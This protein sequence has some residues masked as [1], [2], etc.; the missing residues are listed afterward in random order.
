MDKLELVNDGLNIIDF[1]QKNQKEIQKTYGRSSI[2]QPS[3]KDRTKAWEDFLQCTSGESEQ[4]E[5]GM[6]KDDGG[7]E[8]RSLED[9]SSTSPTDG[10]IGK[11]VSN[12]RDWAEGS[13]DIQLDPVVTD[14]V[15]HD[16][17]GECTGYGFTSSPERGWSDHSS[18]ANNGDVCLVSDAKVLSY[19]P[20]IAVS[21]EDRE[22]DLVHLEDKLSATGLN[23]TAIPFTPK[24]LSVPAKDSPVIAEH[25]YGLGVR[26][27][28]VDPETNRN[29]NLDSIKL[30]TSDDEE[31]DQLEFEDE[32]AGSSS[33]VIVG[34]SP[35]EEEPSSAGRK[36]IESVG[37]ILEGQS[38]RDS[39]QIKGNK[40]ADAPGAGLK[41]SAVKEK[42]PQKRLPMLAEE[43]ECS[44]SEDPIIQ[45]LLKENSFINSQQGKDAQPLYY[46]SIEGSRSPDKTEITS[47]AVQNADKQRPGTPM[48]KSRG[49]PIKKGTDEK[50]PSAGTENVLGSKS[51]ATRHVRGSPPYQEGKSVNAENVRLNVPTVVKGT[52]KSEANPADDNDSLDDK[53]IMPSDDFSNTFFPHDTDRLNYHADHLGDY[54]LE[55]LCEESVLMGVINS[56]KL[57]NLDM[58]LNHIEEQVKEIPK[59]INK[60]E[61]ID[62]VLAKTNTALSTI[63]G[64]LVSM[65]IMIPGKGKGE[66]KGKSN[67]ELK[68]VIG[69][70]VLEQQSLFS[71]DNVKNFRD[72]SLTN[73]PYGTAVQ[74][75]GDLI[76]PE[77]NFEETNASQFVPMADDSSRDVVKTLIR[78]HIKDRELRSELI[79]YLNRAE[80]DEEIQEIANTVND[81]IDGNI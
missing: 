68:P 4:V 73:E 49:I 34:I 31:A 44:G 25:Y 20:E 69:R 15:Y 22:T 65:M 29:V 9:L 79:D 35:E 11:R 61:S 47:D 43:F 30:Y 36:P 50:Y 70:D 33:E 56:I 32:F 76:L 5:G 77:L 64:H 2:Q 66:R 52:D 6:S 8:R 12:T 40:P 67:P 71:F 14:V 28:N 60:L 7:V 3:I 37:H 72:G 41:D 75:R 80:N 1:I 81:I 78:T 57:I 21:K 24:N 54:D 51:G 62:R 18:G 19:A 10:T 63:E 17:G 53:Y 16:H 23:P 26:G 48:P 13:D 27:Q 55:T 46:R 45:E 74:L 58:R 59:I 42:S 39:L 38:T